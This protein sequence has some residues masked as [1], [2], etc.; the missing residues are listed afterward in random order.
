MEHLA[1]AQS[2]ATGPLIK[3]DDASGRYCS[4]D[5]DARLE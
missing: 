4:E 2:F 5:Y 3:L 1:K